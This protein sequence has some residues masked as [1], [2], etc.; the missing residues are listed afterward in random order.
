MARLY[1]IVQ[2]EMMTGGVIEAQVIG[3]LRAHYGIEGQPKTKLIFLEPARVALGKR[4]RATL[5]KYRSLWP[6]GDIAVVPYV[7]R[8]GDA[9]AGKS[10]A[11]YL[12][13][14]R[15]SRE[16]IIFHCRGP[17]ATWAAHIARKFL[18]K[19]RVVFDVRGPFADETIHRLGFPWLSELSPEA[20]RAHQVCMDMDRRAAAVADRIFTVSPGLKRYAIEKFGASEDTTLVVPSCVENLSF[21]QET[22]DEVRREWGADSSSPVFLYAGRLGRERLPRH[23]F[24]LFA[25]MLRIRPAAKFILMTYLNQLSDIESLMK[26]AGVARSSV[27][28]V[29]YSRDEALRRMCAADV[30]LLFCEPAERY[31]DWFPIKFPEYLSAGLSL[32]MNSLV[33]N[34]PGLVTSRKLGWIIDEDVSD[35]LLDENA[36]EM[37]GEIEESS[38]AMKRR[39]LDAC[40]ELFLWK[41]HVPSIRRAY[42]LE[43]YQ[44]EKAGETII[45]ES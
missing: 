4:A 39:S 32:T 19:G 3:T 16:E 18:S 29:N 8:L 22:R 34:L 7:S 17:A 12:A 41:N 30:G 42:G 20:E 24:R 23:M 5:G 13:R 40:S 27:T 33:G 15:I 6:E 26:E 21:D 25:S 43:E 38:A 45:V 31:K 11:V 9:S 35:E 36:R 37:V 10:L 14:E 2:S 28:V 1:Y 44:D